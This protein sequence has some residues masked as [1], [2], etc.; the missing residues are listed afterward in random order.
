MHAFDSNLVGVL[1]LTSGLGVA[2]TWLGERLRALELR[3][4]RRRCPACG[5]VVSRGRDCRCSG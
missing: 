1:V 3:E 5:L 2:M 4:T